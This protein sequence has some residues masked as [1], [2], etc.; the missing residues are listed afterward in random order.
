M[1]SEQLIIYL[2]SIWPE[3]GFSFIY[4]VGLVMSL[5]LVIVSLILSNDYNSSNPDS[6]WHPSKALY[7]RIGKWK[8]ILPTV[9]TVLLFL[10]SL[11]PD[12]K[13]FLLIVAT[14]TVVKSIESGKLNKLNNI[15]DSA[16]DNADTYLNPKETK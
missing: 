5:V 16:L 3:G 7:N 1:S 12:K 6:E 4:F 11:V 13:G 10:S 2:Y 9:F 8:I 14:P 15:I